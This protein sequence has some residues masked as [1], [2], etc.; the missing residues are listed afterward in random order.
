M[1]SAS[2]F[3]SLVHPSG[4]LIASKT[5]SVAAIGIFSGLAI[6]Y[7]ALIMPAIRKVSVGSALSVWA[8]TYNVGQH[9]QVS[10]IVTS[11]IT[12]AYVYRKTEN[13]FFLVPPLMMAS[14]IPYTLT[15]LLPINKTLLSIRSKGGNNVEGTRVQ[16]LFVKWDTLHFVRTIVSSTAFVL[17][18][19]GAFSGKTKIF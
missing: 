11:I 1:S 2:Q 15:L 6:S 12:G 8:D 9:V 7:N 13:A 3:G 10:M 16:E 5:I 19:Y 17:S 4:L 18:L 14:I